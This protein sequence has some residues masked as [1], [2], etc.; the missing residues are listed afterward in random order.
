MSL[1][2][3]ES[4]TESETE[5]ESII[6]MEEDMEYNYSTAS[7]RPRNLNLEFDNVAR[8]MLEQH[9]VD[10]INHVN[11]LSHHISLGLPLEQYDEFSDEYD[12]EEL[13]IFPE[14]EISTPIHYRDLSSSISLYVVEPSA[15]TVQD[16]V[17]HQSDTFAFE[18]PVCYEQYQNE[19]R[20]L[21]NCNHVLCQ[22]CMTQHL[23]T[24][25]VQNREP[26]CAMCRI[27]Y[28]CLETGCTEAF[29]AVQN[30]LNSEVIYET[31]YPTF[32]Q[33]YENNARVDFNPDEYELHD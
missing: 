33:D 26:T 7:I 18:C 29:D 2:E 1:S 16:V 13:A 8:D 32:E 30:V 12:I 28:T 17:T 4:E 10:I 15:N 19:K 25:K 14:S 24:F 20:V 6:E 3:S 23:E 5:S 21:T 27:P 31:D 9:E 11:R 22:G